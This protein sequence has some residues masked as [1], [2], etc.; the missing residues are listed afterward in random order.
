M[1]L[2]TP[3]GNLTLGSAYKLVVCGFLVCFGAL[4]IPIMVIITV[5]ALLSGE[6]NDNGHIVR[7]IGPVFRVLQPMF[8]I[9]IIVVMQAFIFGGIVTSGLWLYRHWRP[10]RVEAR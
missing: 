3:D 5:G 1:Q 8:L 10:L 4:M 7:G 6:I 2:E 9:P